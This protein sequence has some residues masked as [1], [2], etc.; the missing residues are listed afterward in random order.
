MVKSSKEVAE[1]M[2]NDGTSMKTIAVVTLVFL[3]ATLVSAVFSATLFDPL[4][5]TNLWRVY[6]LLCL[7]L[8]T[9]ALAVW[10][11]YMARWRKQ[12]ARL[13]VEA[14]DVERRIGRHTARFQ[15]PQSI[16]LG[17]LRD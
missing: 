14:G 4:G 8:T 13:N 12:E 6:L 9:S 17:D 10:F 1:A 3:P 11:W 5:S 2:R 15:R 16:T 7:V